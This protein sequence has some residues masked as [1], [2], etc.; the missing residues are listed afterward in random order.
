[1]IYPIGVPF[2]GGIVPPPE[3]LPTLTISEDGM[4][5]TMTEDA[6]PTTE[7]APATTTTSE[8]SVGAA[9]KSPSLKA[10][11]YAS[12]PL[13]DLPMPSPRPPQPP[14]WDAPT[15]P[16]LPV[17]GLPVGD[18]KNPDWGR[19]CGPSSI[20]WDPYATPRVMFDYPTSFSYRDGYNAIEQFC[21]ENIGRKRVIG[22][23][24]THPRDDNKD[25]SAVSF[26]QK[27]YDTPTSGKLQIRVQFDKDSKNRE[28]K[29][30]PSDQLWV[31]PGMR[32]IHRSIRP[33]IGRPSQR[34]T[35]HAMTEPDA[36]GKCR[37]ILA[38]LIETCDHD[39]K[40]DPNDTNW[41]VAAMPP[42]FQR[43]WSMLTPSQE[44]R[45]GSLH[46]LHVLDHHQDTPRRRGQRSAALL[47]SRP[48]HAHLL[49]QP[50][51]SAKACRW[52]ASCSSGCIEDLYLYKSRP[53]LAT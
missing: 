51:G 21:N 53:N 46:E 17:L 16:G 28:G 3:G 18:P 24:G 39:P 41:Y 37:Q 2:I 15:A 34:L 44:A 40:G 11:D 48:R 19:Q 52:H 30:C 5:A 29:K 32:P 49:R 10:A 42:P 20:W 50:N 6:Q 23:D 12:E 27:S 43:R 9:C 31:F 13:P 36:F 4:P 35:V 45:R 26:V 33:S 1:M 7:A 22:M 25:L 8:W 47:T 14:I 38:Q